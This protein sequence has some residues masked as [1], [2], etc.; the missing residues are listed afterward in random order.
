MLS[1]GKQAVIRNVSFIP[2]IAYASNA[3]SSEPINLLMDGGSDQ[4]MRPM[5]Q[6]D[7]YV[8]NFNGEEGN[9][10]RLFWEEQASEAIVLVPA[11]PDLHL[12]D[13][14]ITCPEQGLTNQECLDQY[15]VTTAG[16]VAPCQ[17]VDGDDCSAVRAR[18]AALGIV[19]LLFPLGDDSSYPSW[20]LQN[21]APHELVDPNASGDL[22]GPD[23]DGLPNLTEYAFKTDPFIATDD[24]P[25]ALDVAAGEF[26]L[27]FVRPKD[28]TD[29]DYTMEV[30]DDLLNWVSG[31]AYAEV[32]RITDNGDGTETH[33]FR[34][35]ADMNPTYF[36]IRIHLNGS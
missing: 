23:H 30:S 19:G 33:R 22:A 6:S 8:Y 35:V 9:S 7:L 21:F 34:S 25:I 26:D 10:F 2:V 31:A 32:V 14:T 1:D 20:K 29:L 24:E 36:R 4:K 12:G 11:R 17:E 16:S 28:R 3:F 27:V 15:G 5:L 13:P 18:A